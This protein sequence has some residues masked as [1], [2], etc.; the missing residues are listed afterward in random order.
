MKRG[1]FI[2]PYFGNLPYYFPLWMHTASYSKR[3][4]FWIYTNDRS[5][6]SSAKNIKIIYQDFAEFVAFTQSKFDFHIALH[7]PRKLCD[8][9][10]TY[11]YVFEEQLFGYDYWGFCDVDLIWGDIDRLVPLDAGYDKLYV[12]GHMTLMKNTTEINRLFMRSVDSYES[13]VSL[14]STPNNCV[15]DEAAD[16]LN[17]NLIA[18]KYGIK[19]YYDYQIADI[20]PFSYIFRIAKYDYS[21]PFKKGRAVIIPPKNK[22]LFYWH[23]GN[24]TKFELN[25][26]EELTSE[27]VRY[28]HFQKRDLKIENDA[29]TANSFVVIPNQILPFSGDITPSVINELVNDRWIYLKYYQLKFNSL[30]KKLHAKFKICM[31]Q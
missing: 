31:G 17:I 21:S 29:T 8:F 24:L 16:G 25:E 11:G 9:K 26:K 19:T 30:K 18:Q 6:V 2:I 13:Y 3:F 28:F 22:M 1:V 12:H 14:L 23:D 4:D 20:N 27:S 10:P 15:F 7:S 5:V